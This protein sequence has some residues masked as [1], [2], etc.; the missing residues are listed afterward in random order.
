MIGMNKNANTDDVI[1]TNLP[2]LKEGENKL[3]ALRTALI[4]GE[5]SGFTD[6]SL[7]NIISELDSEKIKNP[8]D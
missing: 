3:L 5:E 4:A 2:L 1:Q 7:E 8:T 6:Y